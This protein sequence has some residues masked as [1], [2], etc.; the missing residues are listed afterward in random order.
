MKTPQDLETKFTN[1]MMKL[2]A[3]N[4]EGDRGDNV[5]A[6]NTLWEGLPRTGKNFG[7][8]NTLELAYKKGHIRVIDFY[9][10]SIE[11]FKEAI[12]PIFPSNNSQFLEKFNKVPASMPFVVLVPLSYSIHKHFPPVLPKN[13]IPYTIGAG[14]F[15]ERTLKILFGTNDREQINDYLTAV[16]FRKNV[17]YTDLKEMK[18]TKKNQ[19]QTGFYG[20]KWSPATEKRD[21]SE[22]FKRNIELFNSYGILSSDNFYLE[23]EKRLTKK[24]ANG[25]N[26]I[27]SRMNIIFTQCFIDHPIVQLI[28][29]VHAI[30]TVVR[31]IGNERNMKFRNIGLIKEAQELF[32][33][34]IRTNTSETERTINDIFRLFLNK[35]GHLNC[36]F[37]CDSKP[38]ELERSI[39]NKFNVHLVTQ[40]GSN[41]DIQDMCSGT[42]H[43]ASKIERIIND[44]EYV[45]HRGFIDLR[46]REVPVFRDKEG[47]MRRGYRW[48]SPPSHRLGSV[49]I[50]DIEGNNNID[51]SFFEKNGI[52]TYGT[53]Q[54]IIDLYEDWKNREE[55]RMKILEKQEKDKD[56]QQ[57]KNQKDRV[58]SYSQAME[59]MLEFGWASA[60]DKEELEELLKSRKTRGLIQHIIAEN[61]GISQR[62]VQ[63][64]IKDFEDG[65][66][67]VDTRKSLKS[68]ALS[69]K[70]SPTTESRSDSA[71]SGT[72]L[73]TPQDSAE[74]GQ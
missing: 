38:N 60:E 6:C 32:K 68:H 23:L 71:E 13:F 11:S 44:E 17:N 73:T 39:A 69:S 1:R 56:R 2:M 12:A 55:R 19:F 36:D 63:R 64:H 74:A 7:I 27:N 57:T 45:E 47:N 14:S 40:I 72:S 20:K 42:I 53:E 22:R 46:E 52:E 16:S 8:S 70:E 33:P 65:K 41:K 9:N 50:F 59:E 35:S 29:F 61:E 15:G 25:K 67:I 21:L 58:I 28:C 26:L 18:H 54:F 49:P 5:T 31:L 4:N 43:S 34:E 62:T 51:F 10:T 37:W 30:E 3:R 48:T 24:N 66:A